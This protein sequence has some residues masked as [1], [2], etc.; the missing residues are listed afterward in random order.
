M[1]VL[2][3]PSIAPAAA[4]TGTRLTARALL[5]GERLDT[6]NLE[7]SDVISTAP[8]AFRAHG[9]YVVLFRYGIVVLI[10]LTPVQEDELVR[11]LQ[12]RVIGPLSRADSE[13]TVIE[14]NPDQE[15]QIT[16]GGPLSVRDLSAPRLLVIADVLAK[17]VALARDE[18]EVSRVF[19]VTEPFA[20]E[21]AKRG[22]FPSN[23][24]QMLRTIGQALL[25]HHRLSGRIEVEEKPDVLWDHPQL[26]R[27]HAR[28][29]DEYEIKER[30]INLAR[31]LRV[32]DETGRAL[33]DIIDTER[34]VRLEATIIL[35]IVVE[36]FVA[37]YELLFRHA[38]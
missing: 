9:G 1:T 24:R 38:S 19:E 4:P 32:I 2:Q 33:T 17:N 6:A 25:V 34:S 37:F 3:T 7:R 12:P 15:D 35:L 8:L 31:K 18:R 23:R 22:R 13:S 10:G 21:L 36:V 16:P 29:V 14:I 30:S 20:A 26:E 27:L 5:L 11:G 28:L